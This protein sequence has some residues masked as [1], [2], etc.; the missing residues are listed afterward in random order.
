MFTMQVQSNHA[1][2]VISLIRLFWSFR[3][4]V[5]I[6]HDDGSITSLSC[7]DACLVGEHI[8]PKLLPTT[9]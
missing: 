5:K 4:D 1:N 3:L 6:I 7:D 9:T 2:M 8:A